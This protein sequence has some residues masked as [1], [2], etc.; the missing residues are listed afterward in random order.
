MP[1]PVV[2]SPRDEAPAQR[3]AGL[4]VAELE[5]LLF[6]AERPLSRAEIGRM[7]GV[8]T[9]DGRLI[10]KGAAATV[11]AWVREHGGNPPADLDRI[12]DQVAAQMILQGYLDRVQSSRDRDASPELPPL[13]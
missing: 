1:S 11:T 12:V 4:S 7:S 8:D 6:V 5:A 10:R 2:K 3:S 13:E 9:A